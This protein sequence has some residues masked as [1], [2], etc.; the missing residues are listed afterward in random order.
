MNS[1]TG[2]WVLYNLG[3]NTY[4]LMN[5]DFAVT[6]GEFPRH[7]LWSRKNELFTVTLKSLYC[8]SGGSRVTCDLELLYSRERG[9]LTSDLLHCLQAVLRVPAF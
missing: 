3:V 4:Y 5:I 7:H 2:F 1:Y 8:K 6:T 9:P